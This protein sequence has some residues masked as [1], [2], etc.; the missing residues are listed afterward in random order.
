MVGF[1]EFTL[2]YYMSEHET[3]ED[4]LKIAGKFKLGCLLTEQQNP[5]TVGLSQLAKD[6]LNAA[7]NLIKRLDHDTMTILKGLL[8][9]LH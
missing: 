4:F 2:F 7:I 1:W 5:L 6:D 3:A 9:Q 8:P